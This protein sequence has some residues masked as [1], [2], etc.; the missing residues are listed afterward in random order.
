MQLFKFRTLRNSIVCI[1]RDSKN[2][3]ATKLVQIDAKAIRLG[4]DTIPINPDK[5]QFVWHDKRGFWYAKL[6]L[7]D[8][9]KG[10]IT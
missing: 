3:K 8:Y 1:Y 4:N 10:G 7:Y 9:Q 2:N 6:D 5:I